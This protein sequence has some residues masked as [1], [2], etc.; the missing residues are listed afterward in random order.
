[1]KVRKPPQAWE[2]LP[3]HQRERITAHAAEVATEIVERNA[4]IIID[5]YIKMVCKT[6]HETFGFGE[7]RLN[8]FLGNH[9]MLFREQVKKVQDNTQIEYLNT[10]MAKIFR[11]DGYPQNFFDNF[12]G[13]V[14]IIDDED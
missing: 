2:S 9:R 11:K 8:L 14:V 10:E 12:M 13:E 1:M 4:R 7:K 6:L 5:L 3:Q